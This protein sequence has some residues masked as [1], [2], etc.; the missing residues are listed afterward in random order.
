MTTSESVTIRRLTPANIAA[1]EYLNRNDVHLG[2]T[3]ATFDM[4]VTQAISLVEK[5]QSNLGA[6]HGI[7]G[8]PYKS[9]H[10]VIRKLYVE[11]GPVT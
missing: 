7:T 10:A 8:H 2:S 5:H 4:T 1:L 3:T 9:L 6:K 11:L